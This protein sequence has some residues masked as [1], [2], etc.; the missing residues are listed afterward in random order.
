MDS[1]PNNAE[2]A[3]EG[4][5]TRRTFVSGAAAGVAALALGERASIAFGAQL[6][7]VAP[8]A[9]AAVLAPLRTASGCVAWLPDT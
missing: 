3:H 9:D 2:G 7:H 5:I 1:K 4:E 6:P 8:D